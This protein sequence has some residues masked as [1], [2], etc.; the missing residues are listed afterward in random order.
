MLELDGGRIHVRRAKHGVDS[1]HPLTG[2]E[3]A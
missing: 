2:K 3:T 1:T